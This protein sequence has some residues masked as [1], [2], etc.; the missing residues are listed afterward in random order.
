[1]VAVLNL[2]GMLGLVLAMLFKRQKANKFEAAKFTP[3]IAWFLGWSVFGKHYFGQV[4]VSV[5]L[6]NHRL[7]AQN[8]LGWKGA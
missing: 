1:M 5:H 7:E 8:S 3:V 4:A 2:A 6:Q